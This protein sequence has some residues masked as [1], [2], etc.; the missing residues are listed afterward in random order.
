MFEVTKFDPQ[1]PMVDYT[2]RLC[3]LASG[4]AGVVSSFSFLIPVF[5]D[6]CTA[7]RLGY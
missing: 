5:H 2:Y 3:C 6:Q 4:F 7:M 1:S